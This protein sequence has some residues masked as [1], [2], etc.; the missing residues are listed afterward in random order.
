MA[1][2]TAIA[3]TAQA[4][5]CAVADI[6]GKS[7]SK[8]LLDVKIY[9]TYSE[10]KKGWEYSEFGKNYSLNKL[11]GEQT[12]APKVTLKD[13]EKLF[14]EDNDWYISSMKIAKKL[15]EE[16]DG[17]SN[18]F[19]KIQKPQWSSIFYVRGDPDV[20]QNINILWKSANN[21][22]KDLNRAGQNGQT[23]GDI[24]KWSPADIYFASPKAKA[25]IKNLVAKVKQKYHLT[26]G[27]LN[28]TIEK[29]ISDGELLP[30][31]LKKQTKEV[32]IVRV[33]FDR[34]AEKQSVKN[35]L[36]ADIRPAKWIKYTD[37]ESKDQY[38]DVLLFANKQKSIY[39]KFRHVADSA[40]AFK[41]EFMDK[42]H[43]EARGGS[44]GSASVLA[45]V[46]GILDKKLASDINK[47]YNT[48]Q[49]QYSDFVKTLKKKYPRATEKQLGEL[50]GQYSGQTVANAVMPIII[51][52]FTKN[53]GKKADEMVKLL[54]LYITSRT[55]NSARFIIAK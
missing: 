45:D 48:A 12:E 53:K 31:S 54:F 11:M 10:F 50:K 46:F 32:H 38:R 16:I 7:K 43:P 55:D 18:K 5:F 3:E 23:F 2:R 33:N 1:D 47:A 29:M 37:G 26:F 21:T 14:S 52:W 35:Y 8:Q 27:E 6:A 42:D 22:Q 51:N 39:I 24:N 34:K 9:K 13:V 17:I 15:I 49:K 36:F 19:S 28:D 41:T 4:L 30:L 25:E 44:I 20:M 40:G